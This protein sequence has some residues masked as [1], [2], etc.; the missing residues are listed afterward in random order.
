MFWWNRPKSTSSRTNKILL[1]KN[2][3]EHKFQKHLR[4][5]VCALE[6]SSTCGSLLLIGE[7]GYQECRSLLLPLLSLC[8]LL[9]IRIYAQSKHKCEGKTYILYTTRRKLSRKFKIKT[10]LRCVRSRRPHTCWWRARVARAHAIPFQSE[11]IRVSSM[12]GEAR[13]WEDDRDERGA[14]GQHTGLSFSVEILTNRSCY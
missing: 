8:L 11:Y 6:R 5:S 7:Q 10:Y 4:T 3:S 14:V 13:R 1:F 9:D 2:Q 12:L